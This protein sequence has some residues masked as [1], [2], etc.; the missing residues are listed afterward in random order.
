MKSYNNVVELFVERHGIEG[1][2]DENKVVWYNLEDILD[3]VEMNM[4]WYK[5]LFTT[6]IVIFEGREVRYI[7]KTALVILLQQTDTLYSKYLNTL[8]EYDS[9]RLKL[10]DIERKLFM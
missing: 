10:D 8:S 5:H 3:V 6:K 9:I 1:F 4:D 2:E 7:T